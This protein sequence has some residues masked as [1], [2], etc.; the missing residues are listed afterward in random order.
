MDKGNCF[1]ARLSMKA[2][3]RMAIM[4]AWGSLL[5]K[6]RMRVL[7]GIGRKGK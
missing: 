5:I 1:V 7:K 3:S 2:S 4:M 6:N